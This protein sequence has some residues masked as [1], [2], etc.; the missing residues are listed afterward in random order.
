MGRAHYYSRMAVAPDNPDETYFL[1]ASFSKSIDGG[2]TIQ[3][4]GQGRAP[5]GD[6]HDIWIDPTNGDRQIVA[7]DQ[8][9]S[10]TQNRGRTW[11]RQRLLNAQ[12]YHVTVDNEIPYNVFGNK[13]DEPSYRG[14]SNSRVV[15]GRG[16]GHLARHVALRR[17]RRERLGDARSDRLEHRLVH[18]IGLGD[19]RRDR[20][21]LRGRQAPVPQRRGLA[22]SVEWPRRGCAVSLC[23]GLRRCTSRRTT[24]TRSTSAASTCI[25]RQN[26]GQT[27]EVISPDLTLNDKTRAE[28]LRRPHAGQHR[29]RVRGASSTGSPSRRCEK[30]LIWV[31]TNDGSVQLTRD[32]G[33]DMDERH[34][35]HPEPAALGL[36]AQHRAVAL[37]RGDRVPHG[38]LSIR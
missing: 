19:G 30:G 23:V 38:G 11:Y 18:R 12:M 24:T 36:G 6:H 16:G 37:R 28:E 25:A 26:G 27:W 8:G 1:T 35:K 5:G 7:H 10:I 29:R 20:R 15:G 3:V 22:A 14:P 21:A 4:Q 33:Q 2:T 32:G 31:G 9:L 13:Q 34:A 17:R